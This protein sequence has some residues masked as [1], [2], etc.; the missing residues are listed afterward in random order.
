MSKNEDDKNQEILDIM[1]DMRDYLERKMN[2]QQN[3]IRDISDKI[4]K[5]QK[6]QEMRSRRRQHLEKTGK[7]MPE[8]SSKD[9]EY[10]DINALYSNQLQNSNSF[11]ESSSSEDDSGLLNNERNDII[12]ESSDSDF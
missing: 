4:V 8:Q 10:I 5:F 12:E 3:R 1:K 11:I 7:Q 9:D 6:R 2:E